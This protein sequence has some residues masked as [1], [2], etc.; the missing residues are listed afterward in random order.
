MV[1]CLDD[2]LFRTTGSR[3]VLH[4]SLANGV[5]FSFETRLFFS[6]LRKLEQISLSLDCHGEV[7]LQSG[8]PR[9]G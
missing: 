4:E 3:R 8:P 6:E 9:K 5:D 7:L 2:R 1:K